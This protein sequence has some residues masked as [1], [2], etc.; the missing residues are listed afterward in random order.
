MCLLQGTDASTK[1]V[2]TISVSPE[3]PALILPQRSQL[4]ETHHRNGCESLKPDEHFNGTV[5][6]VYSDQQS[7][8]ALQ[9]SQQTVL[10]E[11][12]DKAGPSKHSNSVAL[13]N[14]P[15]DGVVE[16]LQQSQQRIPYGDHSSVPDSE[17]G[18]VYRYQEQ[19]VSDEPSTSYSSS[20][21]SQGQG[22]R[23]KP[24]W[25]QQPR[26][27]PRQGSVSQQTTY[28]NQPPTQSNL[29]KP[30]RASAQSV[31]ASNSTSPSSSRSIQPQ[32]M[33]AQSGQHGAPSPQ[34]GTTAGALTP[35]SSATAPSGS[36][37]RS[38][39]RKHQHLKHTRRKRG[40][41]KKLKLQQPGQQRR[42][43][44]L[45]KRR[46]FRMTVSS[47]SEI[48]ISPQPQIDAL[49]GRVQPDQARLWVDCPCTV[50]M[51]VH[52]SHDGARWSTQLLVKVKVQ[53]QYL[54]CASLP[55]K[56][57][58]RHTHQPHQ[59]Q[60]PTQHH[61]RSD[62]TSSS[63]THA[64]QQQQAEASS[65][66]SSSS[67]SWGS[68]TSGTSA[69]QGQG[70]RR[71]SRSLSPQQQQQQPPGLRFLASP[72]PGAHAA[73]SQKGACCAVLCCCCC[74]CC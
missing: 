49:L 56:P 43:F 52:Y 46:V 63:S 15:S 7:E 6:A 68:S 9:N 61:H 60:T 28:H 12:L 44:K 18:A 67:P 53:G 10:G 71:S 11:T 58:H 41:S 25:S 54:L 55:L 51:Y 40:S 24:V 4:R 47:T 13:Q 23:H 62:L 74:C 69:Q 31:S 32:P 70:A 22:G 30:A 48:P 14:L 36:R 1:A 50:P 72:I 59:S 45:K 39:L 19:L 34:H 20:V 57:S 35:A 26:D 3:A 16:L 27:Q 64:P 66:R 42:R 2:G 37:S 8:S 38:R 21:H 65:T 29:T 73:L 17:S 5:L 33:Q